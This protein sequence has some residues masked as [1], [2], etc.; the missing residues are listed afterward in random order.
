[1]HGCLFAHDTNVREW[2]ITFAFSVT[3]CPNP[4]EG[5]ESSCWDRL[6][7]AGSPFGWP[8]GEQDADAA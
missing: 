2:D 6:L 1:M 4:R 7:G 3:A 8:Y 5:S